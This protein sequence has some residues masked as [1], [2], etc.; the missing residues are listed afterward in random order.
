MLNCNTAKV[1]LTERVLDAVYVKLSVPK[2]EFCG[3]ALNSILVGAVPCAC[4][5]GATTRACPER[6]EGVRPYAQI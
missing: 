3:I 4:P 5:Y 1:T 6:S 2:S